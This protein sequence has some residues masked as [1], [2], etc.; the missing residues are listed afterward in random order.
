MDIATMLLAAHDKKLWFYYAAM[1]T[2]GS[3]LGG[4]VTY[5]LAHKG[6][7]ETLEKRFRNDKAEMIYRRFERW[8]FAAIVVSALLPPPV[9]FFPVVLTAGATRYSVTKFLTALAL[10]RAVRYSILA[11][12]AARCGAQV[13]TIISHHRFVVL[14]AV[15]GLAVLAVLLS[16]LV[17]QHGGKI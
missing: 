1:A 12:L 8:G 3:V 6:G 13:L 7:K 16:F 15:V 11:F 17:C 5:R 9:P 14:P 4:F 10:G 2:V